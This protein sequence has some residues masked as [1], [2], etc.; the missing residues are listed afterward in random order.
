[1]RGE[2]SSQPNFVSLINVEAMIA[3]NHDPGNQAGLIYS[4]VR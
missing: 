2:V 4:A 1:M 3:V